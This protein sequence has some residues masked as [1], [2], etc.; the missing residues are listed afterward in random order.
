MTYNSALL[1]FS[2]R[3]C[4]CSTLLM[5]LIY[6]NSIIIRASSKKMPCHAVWYVQTVSWDI[7]VLPSR[8][9]KHSSLWSVASIACVPSF[10]LP[11]WLRQCSVWSS[12]T[13]RGFRV[14]SKLYLH[15]DRRFWM[16]AS[17]VHWRDVPRSNVGAE[18]GCSDAFRDF[19]A[20]KCCWQQSPPC[21]R[22]H[23]LPRS[24]QSV[25]PSDDTSYATRA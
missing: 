4:W 10:Q 14:W 1:G 12:K 13:V 7:N 24:S 16:T 22:D 3:C 23:F 9:I 17:L 21:C 19:P 18:T 5:L 8:F 25:F 6:F 2:P 15:T 11:V 20:D